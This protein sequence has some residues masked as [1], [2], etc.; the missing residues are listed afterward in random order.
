[1]ETFR[2]PTV[3]PEYLKN[4]ENL[5]KDTESADYTI[6]CCGRHFKV[7]K[8]VLSLHSEY[9]ARLFKS[10]YKESSTN[11]IDL[12][13]DPLAAVKSMIEY[14]YRFT[15]DW[16]V[17]ES[18]QCADQDTA[19][20]NFASSDAPRA[21]DQLPSS[22]LQHHADVYTLADKYDIPGLKVM[23]A[24]RFESQACF[25]TGPSSTITSH[26]IDLLK[27]V[28]HVYTYTPPNEQ[29]LRPTIVRAWRRVPDTISS[30]LGD[31]RLR[32]LLEK[33]PDLATDLVKGL[34]T[35]AD[36]QALNNQMES[37]RFGPKPQPSGFFCGYSIASQPQDSNR[38]PPASGLQPL[39]QPSTSG[40]TTPAPASLGNPQGRTGAYNGGLFGSQRAAAGHSGS[41]EYA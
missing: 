8:H 33:F 23:A 34:R 2:P 6:T 30:T 21:P 40:T 3:P 32:Q 11:C 41:N 10:Q 39:Q 4:L 16:K 7:H 5:A 31:E 13:D 26:V 38:D 22:H 9:F 18:G 37:S 1:M 17:V 19:L 20:D 25:F 29:G 12:V 27:V 35:K 14:F 28:P 15:Y 24:N 36:V